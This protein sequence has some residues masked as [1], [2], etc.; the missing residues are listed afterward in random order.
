[1]LLVSFTL[2]WTIFVTPTAAYVPRQG[3]R[4]S[5]YETQD[6]GNGTGSYAGYTEHMVVGG[7]EQMNGVNG[8]IVSANYS[9]TWTFTNT[10][11]T[12]SGSKSGSYS[13]S[14]TDFLYLNGSDDQT[15]YVK[16]TVWFFINSSIPQGGTFELLNTQMTIM[17]KNY[18]HYLPSQN[19][20]V[21][22]IF[23]QGSSSY[24]RNDVYG[25]FNAAYS[26][27]AYFDPSTGY[28]IA[29]HYVEHDSNSGASFDYTDDLYVTSTSYPLT[30]LAGGVSSATTT[31]SVLLALGFASPLLIGLIVILV[32]LPVLAVIIRASRKRGGKTTLPE[33]SPPPAAP[34]MIDLTPKEQP[35]VQQIVIKEVA[36]VKCQ[37]CGTLI[38]STAQ[39]CPR[40]G[41]P[42]T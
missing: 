34:P 4:F 37:F 31:S 10:T 22:T 13:F 42:R 35:P 18:S 36:K 24:S 6:L 9:Y 27:N 29:Y 28:V 2:S 15:G 8:G 5:Y 32:A 20:A 19:R 30:A 1:V 25:V 38:D 40:C 16:P 23:T 3:D 39:V 21:A 26:W 7:E 41:A 17:S 12:T 11:G 33:H 14:S